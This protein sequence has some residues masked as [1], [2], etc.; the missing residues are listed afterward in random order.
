VTVVVLIVVAAGIGLAHIPIQTV[1]IG[2]AA[3]L[4]YDLY[5]TR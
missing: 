1:L 2:I 4:F 3:A 5:R